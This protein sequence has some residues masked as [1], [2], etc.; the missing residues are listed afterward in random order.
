MTESI[1]TTNEAILV[2]IDISK[3][4]HEVLIDIPGAKR[5]RRLTIMNQRD[6]FDRLIAILS[7]YNRPVRVA[8]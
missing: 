2:A 5:R 8:F 7:D 3:S 1:L 4:R 6:D